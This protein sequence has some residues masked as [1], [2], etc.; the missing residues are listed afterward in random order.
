MSAAKSAIGWTRARRSRSA[1]VSRAATSAVAVAPG[2]SSPTRVSV[3]RLRTSAVIGIACRSAAQTA[4]SASQR[5][6]TA[7][8]GSR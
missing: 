2:R 5:V 7:S 3:A 6:G 1:S 4:G 8:R